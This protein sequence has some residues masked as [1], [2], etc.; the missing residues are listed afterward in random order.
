MNVIRLIITG[1]ALN[2]LFYSLPSLA[3]I[4]SVL[5]PGRGGT[6]YASALN[7]AFLL[8]SCFFSGMIA[9]ILARKTFPVRDRDLF[10]A[11]PGLYLF[12]LAWLLSVFCN[13]KEFFNVFRNVIGWL[14]V[15][16]FTSLLGVLAGE[17]KVLLRCVSRLKPPAACGGGP[18][19]HRRKGA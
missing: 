12:M 17:K 5:S 14:A 1:T 4:R 8:L 10:M 7:A 11:A 16:Y 6:A 15:C 19:S 18:S 13:M 9:G 3:L 2:I